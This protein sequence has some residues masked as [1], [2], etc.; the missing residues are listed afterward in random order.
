VQIAK[1][2][3]RLQIYFQLRQ[4]NA[5]VRQKKRDNVN[6][7]FEGSSPNSN[8][9]IWPAS[10]LAS[11]TVLD[12]RLSGA[13]PVNIRFCGVAGLLRCLISIIEL[14]ET[15]ATADLHE[16]RFQCPNCGSDLLQ[17][18]G[19]LKANEHMTCPGCHI[20]INIDTDRLANAADEIHKAIEKVP[21]EI[22]IKFFR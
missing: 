7:R 17:T 22:T 8:Q 20:G 13:V 1:K 14:E 15:A 6:F 21:P 16:I 2:R 12:P 9:T 10:K 19:R 3:G 11:L 18:I 5:Y 4:I